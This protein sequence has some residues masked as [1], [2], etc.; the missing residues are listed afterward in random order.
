MARAR[1]A[2]ER[3][4]AD[5]HPH[6]AAVLGPDAQAA[7]ERVREVS[8]GGVAGVGAD[9]VSAS[10]GPGRGRRRPDRM[11]CEHCLPRAGEEHGEDREE[12]DQL[13]RCLTFLACE[14]ARHGRTFAWN[15]AAALRA[16]VAFLCQNWHKTEIPAFGRVTYP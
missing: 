5:G 14:G 8:A 2:R 13:D 7:L 4:D 3:G 6:V 10:G 12:R 1:Q 15:A 11:A 9:G 16:Y